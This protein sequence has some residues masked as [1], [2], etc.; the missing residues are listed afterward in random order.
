[1][2]APPGFDCD[3]AQKTLPKRSSFWNP[4]IETAADAS[5]NPYQFASLS[6]RCSEFGFRH[7]YFSCLV[8]WRLPTNPHGQSEALADRGFEG[9]PILSANHLVAQRKMIRGRRVREGNERT[10]S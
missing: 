7:R 9:D 6:S 2:D 8:A 1:M 10:R 4:A 3:L 5:T